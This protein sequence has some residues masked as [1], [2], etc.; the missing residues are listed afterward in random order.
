MKKAVQLLSSVLFIGIL[1]Y[2][3]YRTE[4]E[5]MAVSDDLAVEGKY[6]SAV[7]VTQHGEK[8][9]EQYRKL[10]LDS[11]KD[12]FV[13]TMEMLTDMIEE[14]AYSE[15]ES[16]SPGSVYIIVNFSDGSGETYYVPENT[17]YS[18]FFTRLVES[19]FQQLS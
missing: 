13:Q 2:A 8:Y 19:R 3:A 17:S 12:V 1:F 15:R 11:D 16:H 10:T 9:Q 4:P 6:V 14:N 18:T 7:Y 5:E